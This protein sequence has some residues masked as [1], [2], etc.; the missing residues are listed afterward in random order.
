MIE[1]VQY[2]GYGISIFWNGLKMTNLERNSRKIGYCCTREL[3]WEGWTRLDDAGAQYRHDP[4]LWRVISLLPV[5]PLR[6]R[7]RAIC[8]P[9]IRD[10]AN[11]LTVRRNSRW[12][13]VKAHDQQNLLE[14]GASVSRAN[15]IT[16]W[17]FSIVCSL[18]HLFNSLDK[19]SR[20]K[21]LLATDEAWTGT[22]EP[23]KELFLLFDCAPTNGQISYEEFRD[24]LKA[25][26]DKS[27]MDA[28]LG[29]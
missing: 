11:N 2:L 4:C 19:I 10:G 12:A 22:E 25:M 29:T 21:E 20:C 17:C 3:Y 24:G 9:W 23:A 13:V 7:W 14:G 26:G 27:T 1:I 5:F 6:K 16:V 15:L 8:V 28:Q 18:A